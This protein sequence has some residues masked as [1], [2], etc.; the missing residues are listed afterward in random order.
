[1]KSCCPNEC[2]TKVDIE[3]QK[4]MHKKFWVSGKYEVQNTMLENMIDR[5]NSTKEYKRLP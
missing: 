5:N 1:M 2:Y 3:K 4:Q